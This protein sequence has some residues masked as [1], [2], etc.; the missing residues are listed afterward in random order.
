[1]V[2]CSSTD[3]NTKSQQDDLNVIIESVEVSE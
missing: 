1:M 2:K 3:K